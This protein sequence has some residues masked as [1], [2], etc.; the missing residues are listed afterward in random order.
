M[1]T[2]PC[3]D[4][5]CPTEAYSPD[6][7]TIPSEPTE[8]PYES[9]DSGA[10]DTSLGSMFEVMYDLIV[11]KMKVE[12]DAG[13]I[14]ES[15]YATVIAT[16]LVELIKQSVNYQ[17]AYNKTKIENQIKQEQWLIQKDT[18]EAQRDMVVVDRN[19]KFQNV[20][21][22]Y[23]I[24]VAQENQILADIDFTVSKKQIMEWTRLDNI[25]I[26][27]ASEFGDF[28]KYLSA[29]DVVASPDDFASL[30]LL[31]SNIQN[32]VESGQEN[33]FIVGG[34]TYDGTGDTQAK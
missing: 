5:T 34:L 12:L 13:R 3:P 1:A 25:R 4:T 17:L 23:D 33:V 22:D 28:L 21:K 27:A 10:L 8:L 26:K 16:A 11:A 31:V 24:K 20:E 32:A 7:T 14:V 9:I 6:Q 18:L 19:K 2:Y 29:A 30:R 15:Q